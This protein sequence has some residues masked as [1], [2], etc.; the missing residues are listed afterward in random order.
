[1]S[2]SRPRCEIDPG[3]ATS[4]PPDLRLLEPATRERCEP[5]C[6]VTSALRRPEACEVWSPPSF[7]EQD[8][9]PRATVHDSGALTSLTRRWEVTPGPFRCAPRALQF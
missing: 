3:A 7:R 1:M 9:C 8:T 4:L 6:G 5:R 2:D